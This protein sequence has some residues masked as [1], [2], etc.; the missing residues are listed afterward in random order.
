MVRH[1]HIGPKTSSLEPPEVLSQI[2][3]NSVEKFEPPER[4]LLEVRRFFQWCQEMP[5]GILMRFQS[6]KVQY[7]FQ[8]FNFGWTFQRLLHHQSP[9]RGLRKAREAGGHQRGQNRWF[10]R[11]LKLLRGV[12]WLSNLQRI[13]MTPETIQCT[14]IQSGKGQGT[15][16]VHLDRLQKP[17]EN[18]Q[19]ASAWVPSVQCEEGHVVVYHAH[20]DY[21]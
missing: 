15:S 11:C 13:P 5:L 17:Q 6:K 20:W 7:F 4:P 14:L 19:E 10:W 3:S 2:W 21:H 1:L 16:K 9:V 18:M 8:D 12:S